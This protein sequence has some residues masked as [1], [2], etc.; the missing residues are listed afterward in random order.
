M[1]IIDLHPHVA[2]DTVND[3]VIQPFQLEVSSL[4]G[5][6]VRV[7][8]VLDQIVTAHKYPPLVS[9]LLCETITLALL[10]SSMLK[11]EG[12]FTLQMSSNGPVTMVVAD[13]TTSGHVRA[14]AS[15]DEQKITALNENTSFR[16]L[17]GEGHIAFTVD[18]GDHTERYQGIVEL[19]EESLQESIEHYF[20]QS[21]QIGT[22][23]AMAVAKQG[24]GDSGWRGGAILLQHLPEEGGNA[25]DIRLKEDS[26]DME[27]DW[28]RANIL[29]E[30]VKAEEL[31]APS[32]DGNELLVRLFHEEGVRVYEPVTV[33]QKC[34]CSSERT[35]VVLGSLSDT[36]LDGATEDG[37]IVM[38]CEF[39][40]RMFEFDRSD[41]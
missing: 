40:A 24:N 11:Y 19:R 22:G 38:T 17:V 34:R 25:K 39:C 41:F 15:F 13:V 16:D 7:G 32:L 5:R 31:L 30:T 36:E 26:S 3:D 8:P 14:C 12:V 20:K 33:T 1:S 29:L 35:K 28:R 37:K 2:N 4:R 10:L 21:E 18:Q 9:Q 23:I 27:E 6:L